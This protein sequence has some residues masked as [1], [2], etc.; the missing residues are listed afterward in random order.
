MY[1][2][3]H[4]YYYNNLNNIAA[5]EMEQ[6]RYTE[7]EIFFRQILEHD[8]KTLR[9][10]P[11]NFSTTLQNLANLYNKM[12][13]YEEAQKLFSEATQYVKSIL[14]TKNSEFALCL[15]YSALTDLTN[16]QYEIAISKLKEAIEIDRFVSQTGTRH[17]LYYLQ[18][19][20]EANKS[21]SNWTEAERIYK[22]A[23]SIIIKNYGKVHP[24]YEGNLVLKGL[25]AMESGKFSEAEHLFKDVLKISNEIYGKD[26]IDYAKNLSI[27]GLIYNN[28]GKTEEAIKCFSDYEKIAISFIKNNFGGLIERVKT[29]G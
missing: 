27:L 29:I 18:A 14:G 2:E 9:T 1:G 15:Y 24:F 22:Q 28:L 16:N 17:Y 11:A 12:G 26:H 10:S 19:L 25:N 20:A 3:E 4:E 6:G 13:L 8:K 7:A 5:T 23:D 21:I